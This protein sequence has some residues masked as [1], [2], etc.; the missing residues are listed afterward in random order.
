MKQQTKKQKH[1]LCVH[2]AQQHSVE[3]LMLHYWAD[4]RDAASVP[5]CSCCSRVHQYLFETHEHI[6]VQEGNRNIM[7]ASLNWDI[8]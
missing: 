6:S 7:C 4:G 5:P 1:G 8:N 3:V 2:N